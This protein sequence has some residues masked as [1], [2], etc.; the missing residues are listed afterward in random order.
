MV[1]DCSGIEAQ[2]MDIKIDQKNDT[3]KIVLFLS[4]ATASSAVLITNL[5]CGVDLA[6]R[7]R[8]PPPIARMHL[9][10]R[11]GEYK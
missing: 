10:V 8:Y 5:I 9:C 2:V 7:P 6:H 11:R 3:I 1:A 4:A